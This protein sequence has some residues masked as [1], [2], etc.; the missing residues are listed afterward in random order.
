MW[1]VD[2]WYCFSLG[3]GAEQQRARC[4]PH[5]GGAAGARAARAALCAQEGQAG[6]HEQAVPAGQSHSSSILLI[7]HRICICLT[8]QHWRYQLWM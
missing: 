1:C 4:V 8:C 2:C 6:R 7:L 3:L 5:R